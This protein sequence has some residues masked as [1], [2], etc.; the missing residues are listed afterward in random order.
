MA[1]RKAQ[2]I[3]NELIKDLKNR[4]F[5]YEPKEEKEIDW[6][7]YNRSKIHEINFF[8]VFVREAVDGSEV[9]ILKRTGP[10]RPTSDA[11][12]LAKVILMKEYFQTGERQAEGLALLFKEKMALKSTP[13]ASTIGRAYSR[14]DVQEIIG[15]VFEMTSDPIKDKETSFSA[16][17]TGVPLSIKQNYANDRD[18]QKKHAGYDKVGAMISNDFHIAT[19]VIHTEGTAND[20][21]LLAPLLEQTAEKFRRIDDVELD[22]GFIS[23]ENCQLIA[24]LGATPYIFP[25]T[26]I[27]IKQGGAPAWKKMLLSLVENP[28]AWLRMYHRR[29]QVECYFSSHKRRF[30]RPILKKIKLRR[31]VQSFLRLTA[32]NITMLITAYCERRVEVKQFNQSYF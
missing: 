6:S 10:G 32:T 9:Q 12:D 17:G 8:L 30:V 11:F 14:S 1:T 28:Q 18:K 3:L 29:S 23:R 22:A 26:G 7:A 5:R 27:T 20:A 31:G 15:R 2:K 21:P 25:K 4:N 16:D 19:G 13:S 24:R